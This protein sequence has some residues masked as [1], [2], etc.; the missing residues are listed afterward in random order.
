MN[1]ADEDCPILRFGQFFVALFVGQNYLELSNINCCILESN[2]DTLSY[3][4]FR[5]SQVDPARHGY[6]LYTDRSSSVG[7]YSH[8]SIIAEKSPERLA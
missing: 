1:I 5:T 6:I 2:L 3:N 7:S 8:R 4:K